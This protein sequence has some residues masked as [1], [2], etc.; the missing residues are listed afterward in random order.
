VLGK[1]QKF[2][3]KNVIYYSTLLFGS[4]HF[5]Q[6]LSNFFKPSKNR[7]CQTEK[8]ASVSVVTSSSD[9]NLFPPSHFFHVWKQDEVAGAKSGEYGGYGSNSQPNST[10][11]AETTRD[12]CAGALAWWSR[13]FFF[14]KW[15]RFSFNTSTSSDLPNN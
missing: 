9:A 10:N 12:R 1:K 14:V 7:I 5:A 13:T 4:I 6:Q 15:G 11:F 3:K 2:K 8:K